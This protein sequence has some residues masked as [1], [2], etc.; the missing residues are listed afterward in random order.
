MLDDADKCVDT[1]ED[2]DAFEDTDGCPD[3]DDDGDGFLDADDDCPDE[4]APDHHGCPP[5]NCKITIIDGIGDCFL[6]DIF[7]FATPAD[8]AGLRKF[9]AEMATFP[10]VFEVDLRMVRLPTEPKGSAIPRL[11]QVRA[12]LLALGWPTRIP[13]TVTPNGTSTD[14]ERLGIVLADVSKQRFE[15]DKKFRPGVCTMAGDVYRPERPDTKC[16]IRRP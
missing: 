3:P 13:I 16:R 1:P 12:R 6:T 14:P 2:W 8:D 9:I 5:S 15:Y 11:E 10:E 4:K 7:N